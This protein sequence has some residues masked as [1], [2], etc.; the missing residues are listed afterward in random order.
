M[1]HRTSKESPDVMAFTFWDSP[2]T[3]IIVPCLKVVKEEVFAWFSEGE[4]IL[5]RLGSWFLSGKR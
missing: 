3:I 4:I 1:S 5:V 2:R